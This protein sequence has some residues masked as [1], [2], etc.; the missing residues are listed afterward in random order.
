MTA[1]VR[2]R[3][4]GV[5]VVGLLCAV[6]GFGGVLDPAHAGLLGCLILATLG[7]RRGHTEL[8]AA[9]WPSRRFPSRAGGRNQVSDLAWQAF[10]TDRRL[11]RPVVE[12]VRSLATARLRLLGVD[13]DDPTQWPEVERLLGPRVAAG[14]FSDQ[15]PTART[16]QLWLDAID[17]LNPERTPA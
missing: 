8:P 1:S 2:S 6:L 3:V 7:L 17:R 10:E 11:R 15:R 13:A 16:L 9:E 4:I 5:V 12:R 14:L